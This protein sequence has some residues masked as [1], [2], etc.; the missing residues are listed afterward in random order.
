MRAGESG[1]DL[2]GQWCLM[3]LISMYS[4]QEKFNTHPIM[5]KF[6]LFS[7]TIPEFLYNSKVGPLLNA[8]LYRALR[9]VFTLESS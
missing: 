7:L 8:L 2:Y 5:I 4:Y 1:R 9:I 6:S 3:V